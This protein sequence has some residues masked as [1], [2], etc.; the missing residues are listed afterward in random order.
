VLK[1][2]DGFHELYPIKNE[3]MII[4][5]EC[6]FPKKFETL[7]KAEFFKH[8]FFNH[9]EFTGYKKFVGAFVTDLESM[10]NMSL[11]LLSK[12]Y[13]NGFYI[14]NESKKHGDN[15]SNWEGYFPTK[16]EDY[17]CIIVYFT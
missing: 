11:L 13:G 8:D 10:W 9:R 7:D 6:K 1:I 2:T 4:C 5:T 12:E 15:Q 14:K 3:R 17:P 16:K